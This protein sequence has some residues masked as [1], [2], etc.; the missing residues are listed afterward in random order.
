MKDLHWK[1]CEILTDM[2]FQQTGWQRV[3]MQGG[4]MEFMDMEYLDPINKETYAVQVKSGA[5]K[6]D[7]INYAEK[8]NERVNR[9]FFFIAFN[10]DSS[11]EQYKNEN[12][13][14][15]LLFGDKLSE[16]I[17]DLGLLNWVLNKSF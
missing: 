15:E 4:S 14:I 16:L 10:P 11:L 6:S 1:D 2:I 12:V 5:N 7:F 9:K 17:F 8:F 3:S 13:N